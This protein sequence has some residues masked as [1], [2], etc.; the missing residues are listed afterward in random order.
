MD[1]QP[2]PG[3]KFSNGEEVDADSFIRGWNRAAIGTAASQ[4]AYHLASIQGYEALHATPP[5]A[6]TFSGLSAPDPYTLVVQ[7]DAAD[8]EFDKQLVHPV[9]SPVPPPPATPRTPRSTRHP[10]ATARS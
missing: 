5:T 6:Q 7:A 8:C 10:S 9:A 2:P 3:R 1:V 4:V